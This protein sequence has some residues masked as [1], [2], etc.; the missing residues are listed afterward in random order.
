V[1]I[2]ACLTGGQWCAFLQTVTGNYSQQTRL[3]PAEVEVTGPGGNTTAANFCAQATELK[4]LGN[5]PGA[6]Y[7]LAAVVA[8]ENVHATRFLPALQDATVTPVLR[9]A[10]EGICVPDAA[11][12]TAASAA[13]AIQGQAAFSAALTSALANWLAKI[14]VLVANDHN[15]GGPT[16]AAEHGV[17]DPMVTTICNAAAANGWGAC[18][19]C[20][21]APSSSSSSGSS[22]SSP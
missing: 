8:H 4:A 16:D 20:P 11:G 7:M 14:L 9:T 21:P 10:I 6:W 3:L 1:T 5:C 17:V 13:T 19:A 2:R 12:M 15:A 18:A 22:S